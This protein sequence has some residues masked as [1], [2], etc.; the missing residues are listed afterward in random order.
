[1]Y[2]NYKGYYSIALQALVDAQYKFIKI[3]VGGYGKQSDGGTFSKST[4]YHLLKNGNFNMSADTELPET[5]IK[6]PCVVI[7]D[8]AY[9]L[10]PWLMRSFP[11]RELDFLNRTF[12]ERLSRARRVVDSSFGILA[13]KWRLI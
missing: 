2:Y 11:R 13:A 12:N 10:N 8:E 4:L 1:M 3:E 7:G 6:C 5:N 9:P